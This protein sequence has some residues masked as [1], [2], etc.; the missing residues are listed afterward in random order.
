MES[1]VVYWALAELIE[2]AIRSGQPELAAGAYERLAA[3]AR[4]RRTEWALGL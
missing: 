3:T 4:A 2:A 1:A